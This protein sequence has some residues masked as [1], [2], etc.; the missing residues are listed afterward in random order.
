MAIDITSASSVVTNVAMNKVATQ[1]QGD[2]R[3]IQRVNQPSANGAQ[4]DRVSLTASAERLRQ[5]EESSETYPV[6]DAKRVE[7]IREKVLNGGYHVNESRV[8]DK[9]FNFEFSLNGASRIR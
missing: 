5:A 6:M 7:T 3:E 4:R 9:L 1:N 8:A 2:Q